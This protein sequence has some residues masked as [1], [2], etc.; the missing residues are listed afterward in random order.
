MQVAQ[1]HAAGRQAGMMIC[2][3]AVSKLPKALTLR[4]RPVL[5]VSPQRWARGQQRVVRCHCFCMHSR[6]CVPTHT[7]APGDV[8]ALCNTPV[9]VGKSEQM[10]QYIGHCAGI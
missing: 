10:L 5:C 8:H 7:T 3:R 6:A 4:E 9:W 1:P 2:M